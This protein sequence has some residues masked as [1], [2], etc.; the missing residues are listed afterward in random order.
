MAMDDRVAIDTASS[1]PR[2]AV[3]TLLAERPYFI[4]DLDGTVA[5]TSALHARA[6]STVLEPLGIQV[7]YAQIAGMATLQA[8]RVC[9]ADAAISLP[10]EE[11]EQLAR[12]KQQAAREL[13]RTELAP[14]TGVGAFLGK[15]RGIRHL[16]MVTSA[17]RATAMLSLQTLGYQD[18]FNPLITADEVP[19]A[20][21][22][23]AGYRKALGRLGIGA[24]RAVVFEDADAG[25]QAASGAGIACIDIRLHPWEEL[26]RWIE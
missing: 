2:L 14:V 21:P 17:S 15:V 16:A 18:W 20:K 13:I 10:A 8:I 11:V 22:D 4:F 5:D 23:P 24:D 6:F 25:V 1:K 19:R 12:K 26:L 7:A 9:L 3:P